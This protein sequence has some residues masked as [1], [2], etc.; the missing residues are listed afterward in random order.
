MQSVLAELAGAVGPCERRDD[1]IALLHRAHIGADGFH[2]SHEL[3]S[4]AIAGLAALHLLVWP[5]TA[6]ADARARDPDKRVGALDDAGVRNIF[7]AHI[8][9]AVHDC[10]SH[11][12]RFSL[13][14]ET[15]TSGSFPYQNAAVIRPSFHPDRYPRDQP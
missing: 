9:G 15:R 4:H 2:R 11:I 7:D 3:V 14:L 10:C 5:E 8:A 12:G 1:E 13:R 6:A